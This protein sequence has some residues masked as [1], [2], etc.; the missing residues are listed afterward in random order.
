MICQPNVDVAFVKFATCGQTLSHS[1]IM[2][3]DGF[4]FSSISPSAHD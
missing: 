3:F 4:L 2:I 1:K